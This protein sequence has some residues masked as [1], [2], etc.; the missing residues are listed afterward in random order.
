MCGDAMCP[1]LHV[2][3]SHHAAP[4]VI[5]GKQ[6]LSCV[7]QPPRCTHQSKTAVRANN[8]LSCSMDAMDLCNHNHE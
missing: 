1:M 7:R 6:S 4:E 3:A 8:L 2:C 5:A